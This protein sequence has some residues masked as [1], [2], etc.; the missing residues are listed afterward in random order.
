MGQG[1]GEQHRSGHESRVPTV[2]VDY[3]FI[4]AGGIKRR[5]ELEYSVDAEGEAAC[6]EARR[7][8]E[9]VKCV[10]VRCW[11]TKVIFAHCIPCKGAD[12]EGYVAT[13]V[14][15]DVIWLGHRKLFIKA[16]NEPASGAPHL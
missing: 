11:K 14:A 8:G 15:M 3:F 1:L 9:I 6:N 10:L 2:G 13:T 4:T 12:E 5:D 7:K 16:D